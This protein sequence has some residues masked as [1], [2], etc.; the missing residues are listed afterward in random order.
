MKN[1]GRGLT[2]LQFLVMLGI[3]A[4][5]GYSVYTIFTSPSLSM[6]VSG[7]RS[8]MRTFQTALESYYIDHGY[9]PA[10]TIGEL[11]ANAGAA[12]GTPHAAMPT[13][14]V[15]QGPGDPL[16]TLTTPIAYLTEYYPDVYFTSRKARGSTYAYWSTSVE[17]ESQADP[18][19]GWILWSPGPDRDFDISYPAGVYTPLES[20]PS[21]SLINLTYDPTNGYYSSGDIWRIKQ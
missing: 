18:I 12:P 10:W 8:D 11:G 17:A 6:Q 4:V 14:R 3:L 5:A 13:F 20:Q 1:T 19:S 15:K 16:A 2:I 9:Y 7:T 21:E